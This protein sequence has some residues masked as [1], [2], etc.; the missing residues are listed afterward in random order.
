M[1]CPAQATKRIQN[2]APGPG[3]ELTTQIIELAG[4]LYR[5]HNTLTVHWVPGH[6]G[7]QGNE[8][9]DHYASQAAT[10]PTVTLRTERGELLLRRIRKSLAN[11]RCVCV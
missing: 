10:P 9:A 6:E 5:Q 2:D 3:Q 7:A 1:T 4:E 8:I 11:S